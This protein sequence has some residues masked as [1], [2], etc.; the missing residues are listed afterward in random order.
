MNGHGY[1]KSVLN[2]YTFEGLFENGISYNF[3]IVLFTYLY[4]KARII[5]ICFLKLIKVYQ[6]ERQL[7][8]PFRQR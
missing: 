2:N 8:W 7:N 5:K 3:Q 1:F 4:I 6:F